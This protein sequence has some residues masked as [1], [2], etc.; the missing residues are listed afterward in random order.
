MGF[1]SIRKT[2][3]W[4]RYLF[5]DGGYAGPNLRVRWKKIDCWTME[6]V[7]HSDKAE[8]IEVI[9]RRWGVERNF[10]WLGRYRRLSKDWEKTIQ[11]A[12]SWLLIA[13]IR[14]VTH[15]IAKH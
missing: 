5:A 10:A 15:R 3:P 1:G 4:L 6:I 12:E 8:G 11:S 2:H 14:L 7:K 9:P 13:H